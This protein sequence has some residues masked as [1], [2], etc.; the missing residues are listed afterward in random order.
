MSYFY[1]RFMADDP[2]ML[3]PLIVV[4]FLRVQYREDNLE[5]AIFH[6]KYFIFIS[7]PFPSQLSTSR[8]NWQSKVLIRA[9]KDPK[10]KLF[11]EKM[12]WIS[13]VLLGYYFPTT[14]LNNDVFIL[15]F[16]RRKRSPLSSFI[17]MSKILDINSFVYSTY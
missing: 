6:G 13:Y 12:W 5:V 3:W 8:A 9:I 14:K 11:I 10:T 1:D 16:L 2:I 7:L 4:D 17:Q 15:R